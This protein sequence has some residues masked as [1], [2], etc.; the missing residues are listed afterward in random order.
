MG[1]RRLC[2]LLSE[3]TINTYNAIMVIKTAQIWYTEVYRAEQREG[4]YVHTM[5]GH[6][7]KMA[8]HSQI[9]N[10]YNDTVTVFFIHMI[11]WAI[12]QVRWIISV[13][14]SSV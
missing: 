8:Q 3:L 11:D 1:S 14:L 10:V 7:T 5:Y 2:H 9:K 12:Q 4:L 6:V 13:I